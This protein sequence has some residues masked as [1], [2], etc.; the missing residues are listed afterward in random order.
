MPEPWTGRT[1]HVVPRLLDKF[2]CFL[3]PSVYIFKDCDCRYA[4]PHI[5][6]LL[7]MYCDLSITFVSGWSAHLRSL[8][9]LATLLSDFLSPS[10]AIEPEAQHSPMAHSIT[11]T[12]KFTPTKMSWVTVGS[13]SHL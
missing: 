8:R 11:A 1:L 13:Y 5:I 12:V 3:S 10:I 4:Y 2:P 9:F 6:P 7:A